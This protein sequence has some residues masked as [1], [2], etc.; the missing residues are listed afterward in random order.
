MEVSYSI[1]RG[2]RWCNLSSLK[3]DEIYDFAVKFARMKFRS[4]FMRN[5]WQIMAVD[6]KL[7]NVRVYF[8]TGRKVHW[9]RIHC[10]SYKIVKWGA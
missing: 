4:G 7:G 10:E 6:T 3:D 9:F 2:L 8:H 1:F 5:A